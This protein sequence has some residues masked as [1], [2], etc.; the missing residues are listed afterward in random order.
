M[1]E[2]SMISETLQQICDDGWTTP[3]ELAAC[4]GL[5][6]QAAYRR[7]SGETEPSASELRHWVRQLRDRRAVVAVART[8]M[9]DSGIAII[10]IPDELDINGDGA[11]DTDDVLQAMSLVLED[12]AAEIK[13]VASGEH[14]LTD[15]KRCRNQLDDLLS[16]AMAARQV[17]DEL[18]R[19]QPVRKKA[20]QESL[21][22]A[23][24][25]EERQ[26]RNGRTSGGG[27]VAV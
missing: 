1:K 13:L 12:A 8:I 11:V 25:H 5:E 7:I 27:G 15:L 26:V 24:R 9:E 3:G 6:R 18:I 20:R 2:R 23:P 4:I 21:T 10:D 19:H 17:C 16:H 22:K 14:D